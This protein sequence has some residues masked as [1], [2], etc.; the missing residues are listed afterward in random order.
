G[1]LRQ[2]V[3]AAKRACGWTGVPLADRGRVGILLS[4]W[5]PS[6]KALPLRRLPL[7][8]T[9]ELRRKIPLRRRR[10]GPVPATHKEGRLLRAQRL[11]LALEA[12]RLLVL[13]PA[14][15]QETRPP[16]RRGRPARPRP[17]QQAG[18]PAGPGPRPPRRR[19]PRRKPRPP[20]A[21]GWWH[22]SARSTCC[23]AAA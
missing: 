6:F 17:G 21:S 8:Q 2:T 12:D 10:Q 20:P 7:I 3:G 11:R 14:R 4:G 13:H 1:V 16:A 15:H 5:G 18:R 9:G 22:G 19:N 23:T